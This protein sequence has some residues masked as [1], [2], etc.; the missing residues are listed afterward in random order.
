MRTLLLWLTLVLVLY[1]PAL[2]EEIY[3]NNVTGDDQ[4]LG[5]ASESKGFGHGPVKSVARALRIASR[6]DRVILAKTD[7]PYRECITLSGARHSGY[8]DLPFEI[9]GNG[10]ILEGTFAIGDHAWEHIRG[11]IFRFRPRRMNFGLLY[12]DSIPAKRPS[13]SSSD[14]MNTRLDPRQWLKMDRHI[15]FRA[16][17]DKLPYNY[18]LT[19][20]GYPIGLTLYRVRHVRVHDLVVQGFQIDGINAHDMVFDASLDSITA[21]GNG[22]SGISV[23]GVSQVR[24]IACLLGN[25]GTAQLRTEGEAHVQMSYCDLIDNTAPTICQ[26]GG[27]IEQLDGNHSVHEEARSVMKFPDATS[28]QPPQ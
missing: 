1:V 27:T 17:A 22:R 5:N 24:L 21:R 13:G 14:E 8:P 19:Y 4:F 16:E 6:G 11:E 12:L 23:G 20:T 3:V 15:Y 9:D 26:R 2:C 7:R 25:N 10:A 28:F 18:D